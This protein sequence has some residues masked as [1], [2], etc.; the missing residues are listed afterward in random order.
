MNT[1]RTVPD[2]AL[3]SS[4]KVSVF[5]VLVVLSLPA[6]GR[7]AAP[8]G[9]RVDSQG[10]PLPPGALARF[11]TVRWRHPGMVFALC[12]SPD[13]KTLASG[14]E[15]G[16]VRLWDVASGRE[17][18]CL[19]TGAEAV[20]YI[21]YAAGGKTLIAGLGKA[22]VRVY[23]ADSA[24]VVAHLAGQSGLAEHLGLSADGKTLATA[25]K[26]TAFRLWDS[27][28]G[29]LLRRIAPASMVA[30][31]LGLTQDARLLF[32]LDNAAIRVWDIRANK[33]IKP[34]P[35][36]LALWGPFCLSPDGKRMATT[37][38]DATEVRVYDVADGTCLL[39]QGCSGIVHQALFAPDGNRLAVATLAGVDIWDVSRD[40][41]V[42]RL[43]HPFPVNA[44]AISGD[45]RLLATAADCTIRLWDLGSGRRV[46]APPG[47]E[48]G[49][50]SVEF[51]RGGRTLASRSFGDES[52]YVW[53]L[54]SPRPVLRYDPGTH[55]PLL[56]V[57]PDGRI[58]IAGKPDLD[59]PVAILDLRS[60]QPL[61]RLRNP[62]GF[63]L[64]AT[65]TPDGKALATLGP[66][67][68]VRDW[69][70]GKV[71]QQFDSWRR[72][73]I[74]EV[75]GN[76]A[77]RLRFSP[78]G[79]VLAAAV[80]VD[81]QSEVEKTIW[82]WNA[83]SGRMLRGPV[84]NGMIGHS[85]AFSLD[86]CL[87]AVAS[88]G[89]RILF[90]DAP[91]LYHI[92]HASRRH[93]GYSRLPPKQG[94]V[95]VWDLTTGAQAL[96]I[97]DPRHEIS[98]V[99]ISPDGRFLA[100]GTDGGI[101]RLHDLL[102][103]REVGR[104]QGHR[105]GVWALAFAPDGRLASGSEDTTVL[106]W[107]VENVL[108][109]Q[110]R[111]R[112]LT[113]AEAQALA[114][115][116]TGEDV[117]KGSRAVWRL[118]LAPTQAMAWLKKHVKPTRVEPRVQGFVRDLASSSYE[119][120][121]RAFRELAALGEKA[122]DALRAALLGGADLE[123]QRRAERLLK[124]LEGEPQPNREWRYVALLE[125]IG[126]SEARQLLGELARGE[127]GARLTQEAKATLQRL[128]QRNLRKSLP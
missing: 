30:R 116:L 99:S 125:Q 83:S 5:W 50:S 7:G 78:N 79:R 23:D 40:K 61:L 112:P 6:G 80:T 111:P 91:L 82:M 52:A 10:D 106:V 103:D 4:R 19:V 12:F 64:T 13:G 110:R 89:A 92:H 102:E 34:H 53:D 65:F 33:E 9:P 15:D 32:W 88:G 44:V 127:P 31:S 93:L 119:V 62:G 56:C 51:L 1:V 85:F 57:H 37:R 120:R 108:A 17:R 117:L 21:Q 46:Q 42:L 27:R 118:A 70:T 114:T 98:T 126:S 68:N 47:H 55:G 96:R 67:F 71:I 122:E 84:R 90:I 48:G 66:K 69:R 101:I 26:D 75:S 2:R 11:G 100:L 43:P 41:R 113:E 97:A 28:T 94:D 39:S 121:E 105:G 36:G 49:I 109:K 87:L 8:P 74:A 73:T 22:G 63:S 128:N 81:G 18:R 107:D 77:R 86:S 3:L 124:R 14:G 38:S 20:R 115:A 45:G 59:E 24:K 72:Y 60:T 123:M 25:G 58:A 16:T 104:L 54:A 35:L 76:Y 29:K 95:T